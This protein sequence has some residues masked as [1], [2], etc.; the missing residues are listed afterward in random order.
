METIG[1]FKSVGVDGLFWTSTAGTILSVELLGSETGVGDVGIFK[2][3]VASTCFTITSLF[4]SNIFSRNAAAA[5]VV[6]G[7]VGIVSGGITGGFR[8]GGN[9]TAANRCK[10]SPNGGAARRVCCKNGNGDN[11]DKNACD[12][13][14]GTGGAGAGDGCSGID[15]GDTYILLR[16]FFLMGDGVCAGTDGTGTE[17]II[18]GEGLMFDADRSSTSGRSGMLSV[19]GGCLAFETKC[20]SPFASVIVT[21][22]R[23]SNGRSWRSVDAIDG[24]G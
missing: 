10:S 5:A 24:V 20:R 23:F 11:P 1:D 7:G 3:A 21:E 14:G 2:A 12:K 4:G 9:P 22:I 15:T 17:G 16:R 13:T 6:V 8:C 18:S 19:T